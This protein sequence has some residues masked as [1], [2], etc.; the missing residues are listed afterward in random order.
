VGRLAAELRRRHPDVPDVE[1]T[2]YAFLDEM[3][4]LGVVEAP[5]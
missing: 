5:A 2:T 4:R 3:E 1:T